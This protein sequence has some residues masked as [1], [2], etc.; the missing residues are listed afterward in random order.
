PALT[1]AR[2]R[3]G[4][5]ARLRRTP[6]ALF[7]ALGERVAEAHVDQ[8]PEV[9]VDRRDDG[10][11]SRRQAPTRAGGAVPILEPRPRRVALAGPCRGASDHA[12]L[13]EAERPELAVAARDA[14]APEV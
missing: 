4:A 5:E 6:A 1:A 10:P 3:L 8:A 14:V 7:V 11:A 13:P 9:V 2:H 12:E